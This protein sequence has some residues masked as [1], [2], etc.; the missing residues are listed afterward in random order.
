VSRRVSALPVRA[1]V[2]ASLAAALLLLPTTAWAQP[3]GTGGL[4]P[5]LVVLELYLDGQDYGKTKE[6]VERVSDEIGK[7]GRFSMLTKADAD[8]QIGS[9]MTTSS[10]RVTEA[11][12]LEIEQMMQKGDKLLYTDPRQAIEILAEAKKRLKSIM[13]SISLN[14]KIRQEFFKTQMM[15]AR[16]HFDNDNRDKAGQIM[17]EIIRIF[18]DEAKVTEADYH[19]NIV[20]LYREAYRKL[21]NVPKGS[22]HVTTM[23]R[24]AEV[25]IHGKPQKRATPA[26]YSGLYPGSLAIQARKSGRESMI[27]K[28]EIEPGQTKELTIDIDYETSLAF[29]KTRFGF[30]FKDAATMNERVADFASR[31]GKMLRVDYVLVAGLIDKDGRTHLHGYLVNVPK[32]KVER[33]ESLYT[34]A[35]VVSNNRVKQLALAVANKGYSIRKAYKPW[36]TNWVGWTGVGVGVLGVVLGGVFYADFESKIVQ[37][38]CT[39]PPPACETFEQRVLLASEAKSSR[40]GA[41]AGFV[42]GGLGFVGGTLAFL[43]LKEEDIDA[44]AAD[45]DVVEA[46]KLRSLGPIFMPNGAAGV[47]AGFSF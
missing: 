33:V 45:A 23:P 6:Y 37:V 7:T 25:L 31:V 11:E 34:K 43:L 24:G 22:V 10:R 21:S 46:P 42:L 20:Q 32:Q 41:V 15:L 30:M 29:D 35:N 18:G 40:G 36:F 5:S 26:T 14:Q 9:K 39:Q 44:P 16:S 3:E 47:G 17:E 2:L 4:E 19:P 28:V 12:L 27:H 8:R 38:Q 1:S 13:E